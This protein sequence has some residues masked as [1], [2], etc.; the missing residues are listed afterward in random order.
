MSF[1]FS[2]CSFGRYGNTQATAMALRAITRHHEWKTQIIGCANTTLS[3]HLDGNPILE[4]ATWGSLG[5][6]PAKHLDALE[7]PTTFVDRLVP[8]QEHE[9]ELTM[10]RRIVSKNN[11]KYAQQIQSTHIDRR[12]RHPDSMC[13]SFKLSVKH[14][15]FIQRLPGGYDDIAIE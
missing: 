4:H 8:G 13:I 11:V 9:L 12:R 1:I 15:S 2:K 10:V 14:P 3:L 5:A 7:L 6:D